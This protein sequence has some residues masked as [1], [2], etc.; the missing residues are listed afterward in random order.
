MMLQPFH[1]RS[2]MH[3]LVVVADFVS[4]DEKVAESREVE[5][6]I[7]TLDDA[8]VVFHHAHHC[9]LHFR[10]CRDV[11]VYTLDYHLTI[12]YRHDW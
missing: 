12:Q 6:L 3:L 4:Y 1:L 5:S 7:V 10:P 11:L 2:N 8:F 9:V